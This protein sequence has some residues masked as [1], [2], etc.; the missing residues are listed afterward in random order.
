LYDGNTWIDLPIKIQSMPLLIKS[1]SIVPLYQYGDFLHH[2][3]NNVTWV[4]Y[5]SKKESEYTA[6]S[7]DGV[8]KNSLL[9]N[10][11]QLYTLHV[12]PSTNGY[13]FIFNFSGKKTDLSKQKYNWILDVRT[14]K[15]PPK[16]IF[17]NGQKSTISYSIYNGDDFHGL[18]LPVF[19]NEKTLDIEIDF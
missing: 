15:A 3:F 6:F 10:N 7:D 8:S 14:I 4:Y 16:N 18:L 9:E 19:F 2:Y 17:I 12:K 13:H 5:P 11:Y 1:G